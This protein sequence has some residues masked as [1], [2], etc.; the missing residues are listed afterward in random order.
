MSMLIKFITKTGEV[1][2]R[3]SARINSLCALSKQR[4]IVKFHYGYRER[5]EMFIVRCG[6]DK[7]M[8]MINGSENWQDWDRCW[9]EVDRVY[10]TRWDCVSVPEGVRRRKAG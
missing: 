8:A 1:F 4:T 7:V 2:I 6:V 9:R 5:E 3:N 10:E